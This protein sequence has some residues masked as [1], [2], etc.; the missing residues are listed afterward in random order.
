MRGECQVRRASICFVRRSADQLLFEK[1]FD[2][3]GRGRWR[4]RQT[5]GDLSDGW[6]LFCLDREKRMHL[7]RRD[8]LFLS[9][10]FDLFMELSRKGQEKVRKRGMVRRGHK[11][12]AKTII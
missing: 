4:H 7:H 10:P 3:D 2:K 1:L 9:A 11:T 5:L 12:S 6:R 8:R